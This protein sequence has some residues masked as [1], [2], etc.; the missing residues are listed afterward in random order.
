MVLYQVLLP[1]VLL[2]AVFVSSIWLLCK[3]YC[4]RLLV[5]HEMIHGVLIEVVAITSISFRSFASSPLETPYSQHM[6]L[7]IQFPSP[8]PPLGGLAKSKHFI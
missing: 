3:T 4:K 8:P 7:L 2:L 5:Y 1:I 6:I